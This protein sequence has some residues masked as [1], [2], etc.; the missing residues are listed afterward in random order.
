MELRFN[1]IDE[2]AKIIDVP[3]LQ[4]N[5]GLR[6]ARLVAPG[7]PH[8]SVMN[9]RMSVLSGGRM[10]RV[11]S[12][13]MDLEGLRLIRSWIASLADDPTSAATR[14]MLTRLNDLRQRDEE[15]ADQL[16]TQLLVA[17]DG[18]L[19]LIEALDNGRLP[20]W[21]SERAIDLGKNHSEPSIGSLFE[22][23]IP[24]SQRV[25]RLGTH[26]DPA[27][28]LPLDGDANRGRKLF[29]EHEGLACL[30]CHRVQERGHAVG[31][32]LTETG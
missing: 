2:Y 20:S 6:D 5:F 10:P 11:G 25:A 8:R 24:E 14:D 13:Q 23:F 28:I 31:P 17:T 15:T 22:R 26:I 3:P 1:I 7:A 29:F 27:R 16:I 4:G 9:Y 32:D 18:A 21:I 19:A 12:Y 30:N